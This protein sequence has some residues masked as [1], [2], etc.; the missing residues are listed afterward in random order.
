MKRRLLGA[1]LL[2]L[3]LPHPSAAQSTLH[4]PGDYPAIQAA[5]EAAQDGDTVLVAPGTYYERVTFGARQV[6]LRSTDGPAATTIDAQKLGPAVAFGPAATR[7]AVIQGFTITHGN[8]N[9]AAGGVQVDGGSPGIIGNVIVDNHGDGFGNGISIAFSAAALVLDNQI[10]DNSDNGLAAG[11]GGGGGIAVAGDP[12]GDDSCGAEIRGN[13][14]A[15][16]SIDHFT[17]GGG[18]DLNATARVKI[19]GNVIRGNSA[20]Q[21][22]GGISMG[23]G[24]RPL[25]ENNLVVD[26]TADKGGG[27][28]WSL[29]NRPALVG[30]TLA[31]N[32]ASAGAALFIEGTDSG[33]TVINNLAVGS[34]GVAAI[35]CENFGG[36]IDV[37]TLLNNDAYTAGGAGFA[38][39][40]AAAAG[41]AGN[42]SVAPVFAGADDYRLQAG[43]PGIDAGLNAA[44]SEATDIVGRARILDGDADGVAVIDLGAYEFAPDGIFHD[45]FEPDVIFQD[46]FESPL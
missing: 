33:A 11:A 15:N 19:I 44:A 28:Y 5:I 16:N 26:N 10:V 36:N 37:P 40:C 24:S 25:I 34:A 41:T 23:N 27:V 9:N 29:P 39:L 43:S 38:G 21:R 12:C 4:V 2:A 18:I 30:N 3:C 31:G 20:P 32:A 35:D 13:L 22:G 45:S 42:I 6:T 8:G 1:G 17:D 14:I 46:G 7:Q